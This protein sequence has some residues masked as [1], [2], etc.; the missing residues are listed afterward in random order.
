MHNFEVGNHN[1]ISLPQSNVGIV[2]LLWM[3]QL[4]HCIG[5]REV[6][7]DRK[8]MLT[9]VHSV[10]RL[11]TRIVTSC[12]ETTGIYGLLTK[13]EVKMAGYWPSSFLVSL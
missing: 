13:C 8:T 5:G 6:E 3:N 9:K 1:S 10:P 4:Q 2:G 11:M 7:V 12:Y